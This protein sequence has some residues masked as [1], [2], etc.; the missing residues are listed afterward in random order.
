MMPRF[1]CRGQPWQGYGASIARASASSRTF[2]VITQYSSV[3]VCIH[4][5]SY[6]SPLFLP[7]IFPLPVPIHTVR[8]LAKWPVWPQYVEV[9]EPCRG[10]VPHVHQSERPSRQGQYKG[11]QRP[12]FDSMDSPT[13]IPLGPDPLQPLHL[14]TLPTQSTTPPFSQHL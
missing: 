9:S 6:T 4:P 5:R 12:V 13:D 14:T 3:Y 2:Q 11:K 8:L 7:S 1:K 10:V